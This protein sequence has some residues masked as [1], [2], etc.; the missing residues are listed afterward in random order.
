MEAT[1]RGDLDPAAPAAARAFDRIAMRC[2]GMRPGGRAITGVILLFH[3]RGMPDWQREYDAMGSPRRPA[4]KAPAPP[5]E[6]EATGEA[7]GGEGPR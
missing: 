6:G 2:A 1:L 7:E 3:R 4:P 5:A